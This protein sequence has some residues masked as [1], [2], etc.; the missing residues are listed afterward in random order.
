ML[1][2]IT[3]GFLFIFTAFVILRMWRE[4]SLQS[5]ILSCGGLLV[6]IALAILVGNEIGDDESFRS[7]FVA[8]YAA[9][10]GLF[11]VTFFAVEQFLENQRNRAIFERYLPAI[12]HELTNNTKELAKSLSL[13]KQVLYEGSEILP[14]LG[15]PAFHCRRTAWISLVESGHSAAMPAKRSERFG[16]PLDDC[17]PLIW[18]QIAEQCRFEIDEISDYGLVLGW[19]EGFSTDIDRSYELLRDAEHL[20]GEIAL[21]NIQRQNIG[22]AAT[23]TLDNPRT[24]QE[25]A[26]V[27]SYKN[28]ATFCRAATGA[29]VFSCF[30]LLELTEAQGVNERQTKIKTQFSEGRSAEHI[31]R[32]V[33][34]LVP[35]ALLWKEEHHN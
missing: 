32:K 10:V 5:R 27:N 4:W 28:A 13:V 23:P 12:A 25:Q 6:L 22:L 16:N 18:R 2:S 30:V 34:S 9:A 20:I 17:L 29:L 21:E 31:V 8:D 7:H 14:V 19:S 35:T 3:S 26:F 11:V 1:I 15:R 33:L 24:A